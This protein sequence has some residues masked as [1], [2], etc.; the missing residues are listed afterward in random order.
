M[1]HVPFREVMGGEYTFS[2]ARLLVLLNLLLSV[3]AVAMTTFVSQSH[4][5]ASDS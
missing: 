3:G 5:L 4:L 1:W 2:N